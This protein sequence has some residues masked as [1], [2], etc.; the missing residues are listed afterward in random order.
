MINRIKNTV[1]TDQRGLFKIFAI[2]IIAAIILS[3]LGYNPKVL[4][5]EYAVPAIVWAWEV[6]YA[7]VTF[8]INVVVA[9][10][11]AFKGE[12]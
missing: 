5:D 6:F 10:V 1:H 8:I 3:F 7:I 9:A 11:N 2:I 4:W 12:A